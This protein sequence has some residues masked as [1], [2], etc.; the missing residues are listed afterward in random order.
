M[1]KKKLVFKIESYLGEQVKDCISSVD[2]KALCDIY[3]EF[4][5]DT[6]YGIR[7]KHNILDETVLASPDWILSSEN[8]DIAK[9]KDGKVIGYISYYVKP[10]FNKYLIDIAN[11]HVRRDYKRMGV[12]SKLIRNLFDRYKN[13]QF[14][15]RYVLEDNYQAQKF[16]N[17]LGFVTKVSSDLFVD[18]TER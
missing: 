17:H 6:V 11:I 15:A 7:L 8:I 10:V 3:N 5:I 12:G 18:H 1:K 14:T 13:A 9:T 16:W 2:L 4:A